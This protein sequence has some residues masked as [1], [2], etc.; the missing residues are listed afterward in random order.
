MLTNLARTHAAAR[1][2][3]T[4]YAI[5][6]AFA[7]WSASTARPMAHAARPGTTLPVIVYDY[8][9]VSP[10]TLDEALRTVERIYRDAG[11]EVVWHIF[12]RERLARAIKDPGSDNTPVDGALFVHLRT[13]V[14]TDSC[15][16]GSNVLGLAIPG[17]RHARI[18]TP[19]VERLS[20]KRGDD[21]AL[22]LG[23]VM[24]HEMGHLLLPPPAHT[25]TGLM[26]VSLDL[27]DV[28]RGGLRFTP[29]EASTI[30]T[31]IAYGVHLSPFPS[32]RR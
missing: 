31:R 27:A 30:R 19:R 16:C 11:V 18:H 23:H 22:L 7:L 4:C 32:E 2:S 29:D 26:A 3:R 6:I 8:V 1:T 24:A 20:G 17:S 15:R 28:A 21:F 5:A 14:M 25:V 10:A 9:G 12:D 13:E